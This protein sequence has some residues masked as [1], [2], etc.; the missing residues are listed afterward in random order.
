MY[1]GDMDG[2][3]MA[4][5]AGLILCAGLS[6]RMKDFKPLLPL[7]GEKTIVE[8][9]IDSMASAGI[10]RVVLVLG[11][12]G[13]DVAEV[14]QRR[15]Y[16]FLKTAYNPRYADSDM[17]E[18]ARIGLSVIQSWEGIEGVFVLPADMP[19][20]QSPTYG[21][22]LRCMRLNSGKVVVPV[23]EGVAGHPPL[24]HADCLDYLAGYRGEGGLKA[25]LGAFKQSTVYLPVEDRGCVMDADT[26]EDYQRLL[27]YRTR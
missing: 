12:R 18:S 19:K 22:L 11:Y 3:T 21:A 13:V 9:A 1:D 26:P 24:L 5:T 6:S 2:Q 8:C 23:Y 20:I 25:A 17:L 7:D 14:L 15:N 27:D 16:P 4:N 10:G